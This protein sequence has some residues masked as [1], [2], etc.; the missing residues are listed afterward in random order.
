MI[1]PPKW[2]KHLTTDEQ[3][4]VTVPTPWSGPYVLDVIY[5]EARA[6]GI[7][8]DKLDRTRH[9]TSVA[10]VQRDGLAWSAKR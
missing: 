4:R 8:N 5:F 3:G 10:F 1:G 6:A 2:E 9:I 7:G